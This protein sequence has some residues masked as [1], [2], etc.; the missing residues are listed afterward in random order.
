[1]VS[2]V[3]ETAVSARGG[4]LEALADGVC[5][6]AFS[7]PEAF[8]YELTIARAL[9]KVVDPQVKERL[10]GVRCL[11]VGSG[12]GRIALG[13]ARSGDH[14]VVGVDPSRSQVR[15]FARRGRTGERASVVRGRAEDLPFSDDAFDSLYSSCTWKHWPD[16]EHAI[17]ECVRVTRRGG[18]IV[19]IE[20]DGASD[21]ETFRKFA[22]TS[23]VPVGLRK[24]YVRF[25]LRTVV[26]VAPEGAAL[27]ESFAGTSIHGLTISRLDD[28]PFLIAQ[29]TAGR[30]ACP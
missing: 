12:G 11:D 24:A 27:A 4:L 6:R 29:A 5:R 22:Y 28:L 13:V 21:E 7:S 30:E 19:I 8:V 9:A 1:M 18:P 26:G 15:R 10:R 25:A 20:I 23:Q 3:T 16:P 14:H 2:E 17:S